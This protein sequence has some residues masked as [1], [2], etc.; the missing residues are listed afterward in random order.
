MADLFRQEVILCAESPLSLTDGF[1]KLQIRVHDRAVETRTEALATTTTYVSDPDQELRLVKICHILS[2]LTGGSACIAIPYNETTI[3]VICEDNSKET[4]QQAIKKLEKS[5]QVS[6]D[7]TADDALSAGIVLQSAVHFGLLSALFLRGWMAL[8]KSLL[9]RNSLTSYQ[10]GQPVEAMSLEVHFN[11]DS[12]IL[13]L[14]SPDVLHFR[15]FKI[16]A[17]LPEPLCQQLEDGC[18]VHLQD[19]LWNQ[20]EETIHRFQC[21]VLP[22]MMEGYV[23]DNM[24]SCTG[25]VSW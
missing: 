8:E 22:S 14:V 25:K 20:T 18:E 24:Q 7:E 3:Y 17:V 11:S 2:E 5:L 10:D 16:T 23:V 21:C 6:L 15:R 13:L 12:Q 19:L 9:L 1:K 4:V